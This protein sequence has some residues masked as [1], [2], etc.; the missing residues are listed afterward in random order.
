MTRIISIMA[1][2]AMVCGFSLEPILPEPMPLAMT[3]GAV[4][5]VPAEDLEMLACVI[6]QE[7]GG[8]ECSDECRIDVGDVVLNRVADSRFP[9]T[10]E[11][12]LTQRGQ[13]GRFSTTGIV[14]PER[15]KQ[16]G[17]EARGG[18]GL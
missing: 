3:A 5:D 8:D 12:V 6:Y 1:A 13:Y 17:G 18:A 4:L 16:S 11:G 7:A 14:W 15:A 2:I 10:L 9:D